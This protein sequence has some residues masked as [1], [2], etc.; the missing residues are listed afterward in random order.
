M[1]GSEPAW[2]R[3]GEAKR[4]T[5]QTNAVEY[6]VIGQCGMTFGRYCYRGI[7]DSACVRANGDPSWSAPFGPFS[8]HEVTP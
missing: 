7:A 6:H 2:C 8:V 1:Y 3:Q 4:K 5:G